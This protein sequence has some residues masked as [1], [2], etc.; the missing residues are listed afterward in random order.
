MPHIPFQV[1]QTKTTYSVEH[2][3]SDDL[4]SHEYFVPAQQLL[5]MQYGV[6]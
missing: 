1:T 4:P 6:I 3:V 5:A 2:A